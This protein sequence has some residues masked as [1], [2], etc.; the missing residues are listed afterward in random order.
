MKRRLLALVLCAVMLIV[1][2][3]VSAE[4]LIPPV[5][6]APAVDDTVEEDQEN[7][8]YFAEED[9]DLIGETNPTE[10][11]AEP[12]G[13]EETVAPTEPDGEEPTEAPEESESEES[14]EPTEAPEESDEVIEVLLGEPEEVM[15]IAS[16]KTTMTVRLI[17][18]DADHPS[19]PSRAYRVIL[20]LFANGQVQ[21]SAEI[22]TCPGGDEWSYTFGSRTEARTYDVYDE[23]GS[24]I[25]YTVKAMVLDGGGTGALPGYLVYPPSQYDAIGHITVKLVPCDIADV[26]AEKVWEDNGINSEHPKSVKVDVIR[27]VA[28]G[29]AI[30]K[31]TVV[32]QIE[33]SEKNGWSNSMVGLPMWPM[34]QDGIRAYYTLR[35]VVPNGYEA[36]VVETSGTGTNYGS[37]YRFKVTN[38]RKLNTGDLTVSKTVKGSA[39]DKAKSFTFTVTLSDSISGTYG[40]MDFE[41][42]VATVTLSDGESA[43]AC[44]LPAG[45]TYTVTETGDADFNTTS[46]GETGSIEEGKTASAAFTNERKKTSIQVVKDWKDNN[47]QDGKRP[48]SITVT[49]L[50]GGVETGETATLDEN[51]GWFAE[52]TDLDETVNGTLIQYSIKEEG[53]TDDYTPSGTWDESGTKYTLT[54][55]YNKAYEK[56]SISVKKVWDDQDDQDGARPAS[57]TVQ[58][59]AGGEAYGAPKTL[60]KSND[61]K[62]SWA[63]LN[64]NAGGKAIVYSITESGDL[65]DYDSDG[66]KWNADHTEYTLTNTYNKEYE[67]T[68]ISVKKVWDD[69]N[70]QDGARPASITVQLYAGDKAYGD[71]KTLDKSN[72]WK[73]SWT[74]LDK[75]AGG[76]AIVYSITESGD[77]DD[78]DSDGGKWNADRTEYTLT[79]TYNKEYEKTSISVE[80]I[81]QDGNDQD[82][83]RP[84][85]I[86]VKLLAGGVDTGDTATLD[87]DND[88]KYTWSNLDKNAGGT[89]IIYTVEED[90]TLDG[91]ISGDPEQV[92]EDSFAIR[93]I[94]TT[95][96]TVTKLWLDGEDADGARPEGIEVQL[97]ANGDVY[98]TVELNDGN[99]WSHTWEDLTKYDADGSEIEYTAE[100][101]DVPE[102]YLSSGPATAENGYEITNTKTTEFTVRKQWAGDANPAQPREI[103]VQ[104]LADGQA[105]AGEPAA[106]KLNA[107]NEWTYTWEDLPMYSEEDSE[108]VYT[109]KETTKLNGNYKVTSEVVDGVFVITNTYTRPAATPTPEPTETPEPTATPEPTPTPEPISFGGQKIWKDNDNANG[110]R[111][112]SVTV[113]L[114]QNGNVIDS[115]EVTEASGWRYSFDNLPKL[116]ESGNEYVYSVREGMVPGYFCVIQPDGTLINTLVPGTPNDPEDPDDPGVKQLR[117]KRSPLGKL[118]VEQLEKLISLY[119]YDTALWGALLATGDEMPMYPYVFAGI[120]ALAVAMVFIESRRRRRKL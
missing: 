89:P 56:T 23:E 97:L 99:G 17:W 45:I 108:I 29:T 35:E 53:L 60:D 41:N 70:D 86:N 92:G 52:W 39:A 18:D 110:T 82:G 19:R 31:E 119:D 96:I 75:N 9:E 50:A 16:E 33:L 51:N 78:Y 27:V 98:D 68:S 57:I 47:D 115:Q 95:E 101:T 42:G 120:G 25:N 104:L 12:E 6:F 14:A 111:P 94:R 62:A 21:G 80:K 85:S 67:K 2:M 58:L 59:Y 73:E 69:Q 61:W 113:Y 46:T 103:E 93:N 88:W 116:D 11:P 24:L 91:Y 74:D 87:A 105:Y 90:G 36:S 66:G 43:T 3:P 109:A 26:Y 76:K 112:D 4:D 28:Q 8:D 106:V 77:L 79:N 40:D 71:P 49:L 100:E 65:D 38:T 1:A 32:G 48:D 15:A 5:S 83:V 55:T 37:E 81:W 84:A 20:S 117:G 63:D 54:N 22:T 30:L 34:T 107:G 102:G 44:A 7:V 64:K 118:T 72:D 10:I 114:L 13:G